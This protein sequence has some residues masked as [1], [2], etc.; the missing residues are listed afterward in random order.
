VSERLIISPTA[1]LFF[2]H[3][4]I[5]SHWDDETFRYIKSSMTYAQAER[6]MRRALDVSEAS[7]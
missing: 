7:A 6:V 4:S 2:M 1:V 3:A 5:E